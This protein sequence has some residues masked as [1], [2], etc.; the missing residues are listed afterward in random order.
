M[1]G[2]GS[3]M[4]P[5]DVADPSATFWEPWPAPSGAN[6][7]FLPGERA[8][9]RRIA[10][11][12]FRRHLELWE[13]AG[14]AGAPRN[15]RVE[16]GAS[17]DR[18]YIEMGDPTGAT[19]RAHFYLRRAAGRLVLLNDGFHIGIGA[20][21]RRGFGLRVFERQAAAAGA[22]GVD[23][24]EL[25][26][27]RRRDENGYYTWPRFGFEGELPARV[28]RALP[29]GLENAATVLDLM[30]CQQGRSWW[31]EH[32][33]TIRAAFD[34]TEGSRS[35]AALDRYVLARMNSE[36]G[37]KRNLENAPTML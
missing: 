31:R 24:I 9:A 17:G 1:P 28:R 22:L 37:P 23:R 29:N 27:G 7:M 26:A 10:R 21:R 33:V 25:V 14:L 30:E 18:L 32:G 20:L 15:A 35:R 11:R 12:L 19:Y 16:V 8:A 36:N 5:A 3:E 4:H 2:L 6:V 13:Y 34:L